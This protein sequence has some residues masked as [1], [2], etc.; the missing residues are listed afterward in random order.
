MDDRWKIGLYLF[1]YKYIL[2]Y[3]Y[4]DIC[5]N[6]KFILAFIISLCLNKAFI[7]VFL[8]NLFSIK[9]LLLEKKYI[10]LDLYSDFNFQ[11]NISYM[12]EFF[13]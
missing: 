13:H 7:H 12:L 5:S 1:R 11:D 2:V 4:D 6:E 8:I 3:I 9:I 10:I